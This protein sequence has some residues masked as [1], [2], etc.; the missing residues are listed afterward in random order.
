[1]ARPKKTIKTVF[2]NIGLPEDLVERVNKELNSEVE[3][4]IP[5]GAQQAFYTKLLRDY[6]DD[7]DAAA[8]TVTGNNGAEQAEKAGEESAS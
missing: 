5:F 1:M 6:F 8:G 7:R 4:K 2:K 3:G